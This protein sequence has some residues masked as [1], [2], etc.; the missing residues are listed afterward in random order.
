MKAI[1]CIFRETIKE[2]KFEMKSHNLVF[3][4]DNGTEQSA[5]FTEVRFD[6]HFDSYQFEGGGVS[7]S[8]M[9]DLMEAIFLNKVNK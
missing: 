1:N 9:Q 6:G 8:S 3:L 2:G 5:P 4:G 7:Y